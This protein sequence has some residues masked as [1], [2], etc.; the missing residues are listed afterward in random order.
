MPQPAPSPLIDEPASRLG[1]GFWTAWTAGMLALNGGFI[2]LMWFWVSPQMTS[3]PGMILGGAVV[4][5]F[6]ALVMFVAMAPTRLRQKRG[7]EGHTREPMRRY[8]RRM[9]PAMLAYVVLLLAAI[10]YAEQAEPT[11]VLAWVIAIAPAI[12]ILFAIR[13]IFLL[14]TEE[15]DEYQRHRLQQA[16]AWATGATLMVCTAAGFLDMFGVVPNL[17]LWIAFPMWT[18]FMGIARCLPLKS[19]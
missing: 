6:T 16:Y 4:I 12:P 5:A 10:T 15:T 7:M 1:P 14:P 9:I 18:A 17:E 8:N 11:G 2:A 19:N 13:A 3:I